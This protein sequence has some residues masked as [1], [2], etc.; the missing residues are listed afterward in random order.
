MT[1]ARQIGGLIALLVGVGGT[2]SARA[3]SR[4][5]RFGATLHY[6]LAGSTRGLDDEPTVSPRRMLLAGA[7][8]RGWVGGRR[9]VCYLIG[10]D[11]AAGSTLAPAGF[12]YDVSLQPL[13]ILVALGATSLISLSVG[14][15]AH[16]AVGTLEDTVVVPLELAL[17]VGRDWRLLARAR[18]GVVTAGP[19]VRGGAP[20]LPAGDE[21]EAMIGLRIGRAYDRYGLRS[22]NGYYLAAI[23]REQLATRMVGIAI[24]YSMDVA[25]R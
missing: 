17:E 22:G 12:A 15:G 9:R 10:L 20:S 11:L 14:V 13:G 6:E 21:L 25:G 8:L 23:Y 16:G 2:P 4:D 1:T 18:A 7:H 19:P 5:R 24:G 3:D